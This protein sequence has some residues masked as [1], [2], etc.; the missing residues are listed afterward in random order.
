MI[1]QR[2]AANRAAHRVRIQHARQMLRPRQD[3]TRHEFLQIAQIIRK[4]IDVR[5][6][7]VRNFADGF[8]VPAVVDGVDVE[9]LVQKIPRHFAEFL[10]GFRVAVQDD[11]G[12]GRIRLLVDLRVQR[13]A[14]G[15]R[16]VHLL[17]ARI[18]IRLY[19]L[20]H[21]GGIVAFGQN[22]NHSVLL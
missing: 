17:T 13:S 3:D 20:G 1:H 4:R 7:G 5:D 12:A 8:A 9:L 19:R 14:R 15:E 10:G 11:D 22:G 6:G 18:Q 21:D 16:H 2:H